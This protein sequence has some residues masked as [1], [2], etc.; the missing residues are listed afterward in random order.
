MSWMEYFTVRT[1]PVY[2]LLAQ[3]STKCFS[4]VSTDMQRQGR[5]SFFM[6]C[7]GEEAIHIGSAA[8]LQ[9]DDEVFAQYRETGVLMWRGFT[10]KQFAHQCFSTGTALS[11][12]PSR[13][14]R[15]HY[16]SNADT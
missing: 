15:K 4:F 10:Y 13:R 3:K 11:T 9:A 14:M 6:T 12:P 8:A 2:Q 1:V 5:I 16:H 7:Y